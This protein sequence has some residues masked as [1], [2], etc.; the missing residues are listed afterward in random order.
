MKK[1]G[2]TLVELIVVIAILGILAGIAVP[3]YSGYIA[4]AHQAADNQLL[5]AV[6]TAFAAACADQN[7]A[8]P[9]KLEAGVEWTD[10]KVTGITPAYLNDDFVLFYGENASQPFKTF[11]SIGYDKEHGVFVGDGGTIYRTY[12]RADGTT[13]TLAMNAEDVENLKES[14][15]GEKLTAQ[16]LMA[17]VDNVVMKAADNDTLARIAAIIDPVTSVTTYYDKDGNEI[18]EDEYFSAYSGYESD[19]KNAHAN[20]Y[21]DITET[22]EEYKTY[23][24]W[25]KNSFGTDC[26]IELYRKV[27][28]D[29]A[30]NS[31]A[32]EQMAENYSYT[33]GD[34]GF[35]SYLKSLGMT[36]ERIDNMSNT[37]KA[38]ALVL[39]TAG[40][41]SGLKA[42]N[43]L[44]SLNTSTGTVDSGLLNKNGISTYALEKVLPYAL[45]M[46]YSNSSYAT[47]IVTEATDD[48]Q[49]SYQNDGTAKITKTAINNYAGETETEKLKAFLADQ[50]PE[51]KD[52]EF[53][54]ETS[55]SGFKE[56][57]TI[58]LTGTGTPA[59]SQSA[60]SYFSNESKNNLSGYS[61]V[62]RIAQT[63]MQTEGF[64]QYISSGQALTDTEGFIGAM[65]MIDANAKNVG[66][67]ELLTSGYNSE[68]LV[69]IVNE[70]LTSGN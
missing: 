44:A 27:L 49:L 40:G 48:I 9:T 58:T 61:D 12:T 19:Y 30:A 67:E 16:E 43:V 3:V 36:Q 57:Y 6:N 20:D 10:N 51:Y 23:A 41:A 65:N 35:T 56:V 64:Q 53:T 31:Y 11:T 70:L 2:F 38:N 13:V 60:S 55:G 32:D 22:S 17:A 25:Y 68:T 69:D 29:R 4:K 39:Y 45:A 52:N 8:D 46:A 18:T 28:L 5:A 7:G 33:T 1:S 37:E 24:E 34:G 14:T 47:D 63:L 15:F 62:T 21:D 50:Y 54:F 66:W 26:T 42:E 59:T